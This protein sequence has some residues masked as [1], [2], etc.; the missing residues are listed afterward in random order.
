MNQNLIKT[1]HTLQSELS[2]MHPLHSLMN[3]LLH[4]FRDIVQLQHGQ[5]PEREAGT[6]E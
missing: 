6:K 1:F 4:S 5:H 2:S 3:I